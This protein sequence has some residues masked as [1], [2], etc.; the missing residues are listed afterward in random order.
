MAGRTLP[1]NTCC[2]CLQ[3]QISVDYFQ[4]LAIFTSARVKWPPLIREVFK[5]SIGKCNAHANRL[6]Q[7]EGETLP[8]RMVWHNTGWGGNSCLSHPQIPN[9]AFFTSPPSELGV[10][11]PIVFVHMQLMSAFNLNIE[12]AAPECITPDLSYEQKFLGIIGLPAVAIATMGLI[13]LL[14]YAWKAF[15]RR[16][17]KGQRTTHLP[18]LLGAGVLLMIFIY[19]QETKTALDAF[20]CIQTTPPDGNANGYL[21]AVFEPCYQPGGVHLRILPFGAIA[22]VFYTLGL[23]VM[24]A[25]VLWRGR[26]LIPYAQYLRAQG[27]E[28]S[29]HSQSRAK[30]FYDSYRRVL[31]MFRPETYWW[32]LAVIGRKFLIAVTSLLFNTQPGFQLSLTLLILFVSYTVQVQ[33]RPYMS[34]GDHKQVVAVWRKRERRQ[35]ELDAA[36]RE[37]RTVRKRATGGLADEFD[38]AISRSEAAQAA[39]EVTDA[40]FAGGATGSSTAKALGSRGIGTMTDIE[41]RRKEVAN[42]KLGELLYSRVLDYNNFEG[43]LLSSAIFIT[44]AGVCFESGRLDDEFYQLQRDVLTYATIVVIMLSLAYVFAVF[45]YDVIVTLDPTRRA[46]CCAC[47]VDTSKLREARRK[48]QSIYKMADTNAGD[49]GEDDDMAMSAERWERFKKDFKQVYTVIDD[50]RSQLEVATRDRD[51]E[52][53]RMRA[54]DSAQARTTNRARLKAGRARRTGKQDVSSRRKF[55]QKRAA[56]GDDNAAITA[57]SARLRGTT[58]EGTSTATSTAVG[59]A[60]AAVSGDATKGGASEVLS[61]AGASKGMAALREK[62]IRRKS[63]VRKI[64]ALTGGGKKP[65]AGLQLGGDG[66]DSS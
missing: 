3:I 50:L 10:L 6:Q 61:K 9:P 13:G 43:V 8:T 23:P 1:L 33:L 26:E 21:Q 24:L 34:P 56:A 30:A 37:G 31:Y 51:A 7:V 66:S 39:D 41:R 28:L 63:S 20:N 27:K 52:V 60:M 38:E 32:M 44:L 5:V 16:A 35:A 11:F 54:Q 4:V 17:K 45:A 15:V 36:A 59:R 48:R 65:G 29:S 49:G 47:C 62:T 14:G 25:T 55:D 58:S 64:Q 12:L 18:G 46:T 42:M 22:V 19:M 57:A 2:T 40:V 53:A